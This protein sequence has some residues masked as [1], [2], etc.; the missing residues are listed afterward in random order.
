MENQQTQPT[1][2]LGI[3][4]GPHWWKASALTTAPTLLPKMSGEY[5]RTESGEI[6]KKL[7]LKF[8]RRKYL[9][10]HIQMRHSNNSNNNNE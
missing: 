4:P 6:K 3:D 1:S 2:C 7:N 5:Q 9:Y 8:I 10:K